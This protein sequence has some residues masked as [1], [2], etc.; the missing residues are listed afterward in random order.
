MRILRDDEHFYKK[1]L[2]LNEFDIE[3]TELKF[4][5]KL[6]N[7]IHVVIL[8]EKYELEKNNFLASLGDVL[9]K[10]RRDIEYIYI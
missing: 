2:L 5:D 1:V 10:K 8:P 3:K 4:D 9:N 6:L 7:D